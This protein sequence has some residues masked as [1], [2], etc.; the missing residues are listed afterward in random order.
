MY[1]AKRLV[2]LLVVLAAVCLAAFAA[3][4]WEQHQ[5]QIRTSGQV[6]LEIDSDSVQALS[7]SYEDTALAFHRDGD[8]RYDE[9][10]AF[11]VDQEVIAGLLEPFQAFTAAF[12]IE[13]VEDYGQY[14]LDDPVCTIQ[15]T[16]GEESYEIAL[17][18]Y[19]V[20][21]EQRYVCFGDGNV[22][23]A[24]SD[25]M[26]VYEIV[27][28]DCIQ[29]DQIPDMDQVTSLAFSGEED[30]E[31][32]YQE[33]GSAWS[34]CGDDVY[35]TQRDGD[36]LPL[37]TSRVEDYLSSLETVTL[38]NYVDYDA[39]QEE[40]AQYGLDDPELTVTV[41]YTAQGEDGEEI[42][43]TFTLH[44]SRDPE[45]LAQAEDAD[46][47][48][49]DGEEGS[50]T[51]YVR[52]EG[53]QIVYQLLSGEYEQLMAASYDDLRHREV[54]T[55]SFDGIQSIDVSLEGETHTFT[56]QGEGEERTWT[57]Q[58][59]EVDISD[60]QAAVEGLSAQSFTQEQPDQQLEIALTVHLDDDT[61][62]Q[63][64]VE[65]YRYDGQTCLAVVDG[66][67]VC[68]TARGDVVDL[69]EAVQAIVLGQAGEG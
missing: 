16:A 17:G 57:Y 42:S 34:Y 65:L 29:N 3:I 69:I 36:T 10:E 63:V 51:A 23:L 30:Y 61:F 40:L 26:E 62:P 31:I 52:V 11:P 18:D 56:A 8:W 46:A 33:D 68:L 6:V 13:D 20:M 25:P 43:G 55:A 7:W 9:D 37:D 32:V 15:L 39:A 28:E 14:G 24:Q 58:D 35:F 49:D 60:L 66:A 41:E 21:D 5:E 1:R 22:Y 59:Q 2:I 47:G 45:E 54:L 48:T 64:T 27:L 67:P 12:V 38:S 53:S 4:R 19:S 44:I 50:V